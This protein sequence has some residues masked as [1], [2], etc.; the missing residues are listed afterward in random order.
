MGEPVKIYDLATQMI[1]LSGLVP[2]QDIAIKITGT[3][4][5]EKIYEELLIAGDNIQPT[6]HKRIYS[7]QEPFIPWV[8]LEPLLTQLLQAVCQNDPDT[9]YA[10]LRR[11]VPE[12]T[13][14]NCLAA[15]AAPQ[16]DPV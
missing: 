14:A 10:L 6:R 12:Y 9:T 16:V 5:G 8:T 1:R 2:E 7:S 4:P 15:E 13:V 3:R 11:M